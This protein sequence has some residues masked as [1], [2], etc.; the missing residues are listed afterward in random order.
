MSAY[1]AGAETSRYPVQYECDYVERRSRLT[2][3]FRLILA[4]PHYF[5]L[6]FYGIVVM[7]AV[8]IAWFALLFTARWPQ[9]LYNFVAGVLRYAAR[10][11]GYLH[12]TTDAYPPFDLGQHD[13]YPLRLRIA[14]A[15]ESYSRAKVF[16]RLL[17]AIPVAIIA[18]A[19]YLV[20]ELGS[21]IAW[22]AIV[23]TGKQP[24]GLQ[25]MINLGV[26]Y[27]V[28]AG[29]YFCLL[30]EDWPPFSAED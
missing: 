23:I 3:F 26:A 7:F 9:G 19:L 10:L 11:Y 15:Q 25:S 29:A 27:Y 5:V 24:P 20:A 12:L 30:T 2:T 4:F 8:L 22:F 18:Y 17:L 1:S 14:P 21:L 6:T 13:E 28:R 16:F